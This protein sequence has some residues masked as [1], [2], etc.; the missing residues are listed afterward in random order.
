MVAAGRAFLGLSGKCESTILVR[1]P[2]VKQRGRLNKP[3]PATLQ[4]FGEHLKKTK[5]RQEAYAAR[6][7]RKD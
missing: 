1:E 3:Y 2:V 6:S 7:G 4:T 5:V